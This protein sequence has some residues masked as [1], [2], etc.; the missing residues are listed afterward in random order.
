MR[1]SLLRRPSTS[2]LNLSRRD[3]PAYLTEVERN[4]EAIAFCR[5]AVTS[6]DPAERPRLLQAW[7]LA[8]DSSGGSTREALALYRA[9]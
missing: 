1:S 7:A 5:G 3:G 8:I 4:D 6:A 9:A 2:T